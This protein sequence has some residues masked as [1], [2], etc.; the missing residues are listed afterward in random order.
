M[1][2]V[3]L[4]TIGDE[5]CI[6]QIINTNA[7]W[8]A[9]VC[10]SLG[11]SVD[12]HSSVRD[13]PGIMKSELQRLLSV[14]DM[15][16]MTGGLGPTHDDMTKPV[17][18]DFFDDKLIL[19][20]DSLKQVEQIFIRRGMTITDRNRQQAYLP[21]KCVPLSNEVG[22]APGMLFE[23]N[24]KYII[25]MPGVPN[26]MKFIMDNHVLPMIQ[27][28]LAE[29][30]YDVLAYKNLLTAGIPE[31]MLADLIGDP[32]EFLD[33]GTLAFLPSYQGVRL[34]IGYSS[35]SLESAM[36]K[37]SVI[38]Q[39]IR[40]RAGKYIYGIGEDNLSAA[41]GKIL[42]EKGKTVSVAESCTGGMLGGSITDIPGSSD[43][44][45]GGVIVYS[46][47]AKIRFLSVSPDTIER[48]GAVSPETASE[49]A[50]GVRKKFN[51]DYGIS[52]TGI[53]GPD[54][55]TDDKPV[56]LVW[57]GLSGNKSTTTHKFIFGRDRKVNRERSV[58]MALTLLLDELR[59]SR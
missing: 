57:I 11:C 58:G 21:S 3:S 6:G 39:I 18:L 15:V 1:F 34:R 54:G 48:F 5:I 14:S 40:E 13:E 56:G 22:T 26:E 55:G 36:E 33:G 7:A 42:K 59:K 19:H 44:F 49:M 51:T 43:Y 47:E 50:E 28:I 9:N 2:K 16:L 35:S 41:I 23:T 24:G 32:Y 17:L 52:V 25:S 10:T 29:K 27:R 38:E 8:M 45:T 12:Q 37:I 46:N 53:A 4:L 31:S 30:K 20:E